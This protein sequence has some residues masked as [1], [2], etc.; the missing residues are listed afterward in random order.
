MNLKFPENFVWGTS[1]AATQIETA[2]EHD[3][4]GE[5]SKDGYVF[6]QTAEHEK[7]RSEDLQYIIK[8]GNSYRMSLDWARLQVA[9]FAP[10]SAEVVGEYRAFMAKLQV[11]NIHIKLVIHH[12]TNPKW[13]VTRGSWE[14]S[15]NIELF[16]NYVKQLCLHFGD[17]VD[18][19]N[20]FN[21]PAVYLFNSRLLGDFPPHKKNPFLF[22]KALKNMSRAHRLSIKILKYLCPYTPIGMSKNTAIFEGE[23]WLGGQLA[24]VADKIFMDEIADAFVEGLDYLGI[25][26]YAKIPFSPWPITEI[27]QPGKL[28]EMG[29]KHDKMWEYYP[30]GLKENIKRYWEK[31]KLPIVITE[32][33]ICTDDCE[34]RISAIKDYLKQVHECIEEGV[35][36]RGYF[37]WSTMDNFEWNLGPTYRFGLVHV[38]FESGKRTMKK[39][40]LFYQEVVRNNGIFEYMQD[41]DLREEGLPTTTFELENT[42]LPTA[43][44]LE[45]EPEMS[46]EE[47]DKVYEES[48]K[49]EEITTDNDA[50]L[51]RHI[52]E[53]LLKDT[54]V[55]RPENEV[56]SSEDE[57]NEKQDD[58]D[59]K[60]DT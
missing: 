12:F 53:N 7:H 2:S 34:Q 24:K 5:K 36:V 15:K 21:E 29:R 45:N 59:N 28:A 31:Y 51:E 35:D 49:E 23:N 56:A 44:V 17:F 52:D 58:S 47:A 54:W 8:F 26:Y 30:E 41:E 20:T 3:W 38:D 11:R 27:K 37:H 57:S 43:D 32:N 55:T 10:F 1:T 25:S 4:K 14:N 39:S 16:L 42:V 19:W 40:G 18:S 48:E 22:R 6:E 50:E 60:K 33:G 13:F 46:V 9:P